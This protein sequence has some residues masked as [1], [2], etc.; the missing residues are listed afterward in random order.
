MCI[1]FSI[2]CN[3]FCGGPRATGCDVIACAQANQKIF[4]LV[5]KKRIITRGAKNDLKMWRET[6]LQALVISLGVY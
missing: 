3:T 2:H 4:S 5:C 6:C 1:E